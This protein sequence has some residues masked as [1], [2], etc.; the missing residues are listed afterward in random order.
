MA[1]EEDAGALLDLV[2]GEEEGGSKEEG[3]KEAVLAAFD[4]VNCATFV[5]RC[6]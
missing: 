5:N 6:G 2:L 4:K 1:R 3:G